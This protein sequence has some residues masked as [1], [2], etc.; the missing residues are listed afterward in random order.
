MSNNIIAEV[1][2]DGIKFETGGKSC[3]LEDQIVKMMEEYGIKITSKK[4][5]ATGGGES[6]LQ[7]VTVTQ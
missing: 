5:V 2:P 7:G 1:T 3:G 6:Q 4:V